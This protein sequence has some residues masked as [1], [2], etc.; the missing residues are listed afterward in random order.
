VGGLGGRRHLRGYSDRVR[1]TVI[2]L[3]PCRDEA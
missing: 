2:L 1:M 3:L